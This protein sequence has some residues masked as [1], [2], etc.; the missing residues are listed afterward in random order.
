MSEQV[1]SLSLIMKLVALSALDLA[2]LRVQ[3]H[4]L[5][6]PL[7]LFALVALDLVIIQIFILS[8]RLGPFY[9]TFL[10][11]GLV[12]SLTLHMFFDIGLSHGISG[13]PASQQS[14]RSLAIAERGVTSTLGLL[15]AWATGLWMGAPATRQTTLGA[16]RHSSRVQ[17]SAWV[18]SW[19]PSLLSTTPDRRQICSP[20][21][22][23]AACWRADWRFAHSSAVR[24]FCSLEAS[25]IFD[26]SVNGLKTGHGG[27]DSFKTLRICSSLKS[28]R[29]ALR[30]TLRKRSA[31]ESV[32]PAP[33][34]P[35]PAAFP[36]SRPRKPG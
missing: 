18:S 36:V 15:L 14:A 35:G 19:W 24:Q 7:F 21:A 28:N 12:A 27:G 1:V 26:G 6:S 23:L 25:E 9:F 29:S 10:I 16:S 33:N 30:S 34:P 31:S 4:R 32:W 5:Q 3:P 20:P 2:F 17:S 22:N 11:V 8:R 13:T